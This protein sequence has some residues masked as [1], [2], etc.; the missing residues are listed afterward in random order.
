MKASEKKQQ[1]KIE[2]DRDTKR[3]GKDEIQKTEQ[4]RKQ[5]KI[6]MKKKT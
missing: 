5:Q 1:K 3:G 2:S 4:E 6:T